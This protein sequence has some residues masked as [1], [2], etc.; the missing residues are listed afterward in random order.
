V[1]SAGLKAMRAKN[2]QAGRWVA[3]EEVFELPLTGLT[4]KILHKLGLF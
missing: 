1:V 4:R 3:Q 2:R